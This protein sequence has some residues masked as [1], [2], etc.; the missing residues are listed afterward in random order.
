MTQKQVEWNAD[1]FERDALH[2]NLQKTHA[3]NDELSREIKLREREVFDFKNSPSKRKPI[4]ASGGPL[5]GLISCLRSLMKL[6][7]HLYVN[8]NALPWTTD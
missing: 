6:V 3:I 5:V 2:R 4:E 7:Y 1:E 8:V